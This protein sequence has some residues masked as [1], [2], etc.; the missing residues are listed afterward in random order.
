MRDGRVPQARQWTYQTWDNPFRM[1]GPRLPRRAEGAA[2][3]QTVLLVCGLLG[4]VVLLFQIAR[5][6]PKVESAKEKLIY[7]AVSNSRGGS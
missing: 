4:R 5:H 3:D 7:V 2:K 1:K 6:F